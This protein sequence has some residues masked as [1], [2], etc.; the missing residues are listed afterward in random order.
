[1]AARP[2]TDMLKD[3]DR[4]FTNLY[5]L[6]DWRLAGAC[7]RG[8]WDGTKDLILKGRDWIVEQMK[9]SGLRGL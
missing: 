8:D 1:M 2:E 9:L 5:G 7:S 4:I 3:S 6:H